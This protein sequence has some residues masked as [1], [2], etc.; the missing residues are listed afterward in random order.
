LSNKLNAEQHS[1][2]RLEVGRVLGRVPGVRRGVREAKEVVVLRDG[3]PWIWTIADLHFHGA[4]Q[5][6]DLYHALEHITL[7][8]KSVYPVMD[9]RARKWLDHRIEQVKR[10]DIAGVV[11]S[12]KR[13]HP[14]GQESSSLLSREIEYFQKNRGRMRYDEFR[15]RVCS[16]DRASWKLD[17]RQ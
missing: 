6:L 3:A 7:I 9:R 14:E 15:E 16:S 2:K 10:G 1:G 17:A 13:L 4:T 5:I 11:R 12:L 8:G